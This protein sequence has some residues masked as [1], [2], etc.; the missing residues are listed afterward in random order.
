MRNRGK[1]A[2]EIP[3]DNIPLTLSLVINMMLMVADEK[4]CLDLWENSD[5]NLYN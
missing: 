1:R 4:L 2:D 5:A 3:K